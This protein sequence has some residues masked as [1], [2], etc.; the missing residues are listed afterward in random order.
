M[1]TIVLLLTFICV[2]AGGF[3][4]FTRASKSKQPASTT[5]ASSS[6]QEEEKKKTEPKQEQQPQ[7]QSKNVPPRKKSS[8]GKKGEYDISKVENL[9]TTLKGGIEAQKAGP[10]IY[11]AASE[12][13]IATV[14]ESDHFVRLWRTDS[15]FSSD[16]KCI[17]VK[18]GA[19]TD[20]ATACA[21]SPDSRY[22][23]FGLDY[24]NTV[25]IYDLIDEKNPK[26]LVS[27]SENKKEK[28][29]IQHMKFTDDGKFV[30][31]SGEKTDEIIIWRTNKS[32]SIAHRF[33]T[34][35]LQVYMFD[36]GSVHDPIDPSKQVL[37]CATFTTALRVFHL[38][39]N[40][41]NPDVAKE[42]T[43]LS[44][45][46]KP[47]ICVSFNPHERQLITASKDGT[48]KIFTTLS[49]RERIE[50]DRTSKGKVDIKEV[51][52]L[53]QPIAQII[54]SHPSLQDDQSE[55]AWIQYLSAD[56][57]VLLPTNQKSLGI[58]KVDKKKKNITVSHVIEDA[59]LPDHTV[60]CIARWKDDHF[61]TGDSLGVTRIWKV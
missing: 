35:T 58:L 32:G 6:Q 25:V 7:Q 14:R 40:G 54:G 34:G 28:N 4:A 26:K 42:V 11:V 38:R 9:L 49:E 5:N 31:T 61:V 37:S 52:F 20:Y 27:E 2:I 16:K 21:I 56:T 44:G 59:V 50:K 33:G 24:F 36:L 57:L 8:G 3:Y 13:Y 48:I 10:V 51:E 43:G 17:L 47:T 22:L 46:T 30:V 45:H 12:K 23:A 15:A 29:K 18:C 39:T 41:D 60:N 1:N 19:S 55:I 53:S